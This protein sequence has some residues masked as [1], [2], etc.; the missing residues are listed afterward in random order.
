MTILNLGF[1][2]LIAGFFEYLNHQALIRMWNP[3]RVYGKEP[4]RM[5]ASIY[6]FD[7][8]IYSSRKAYTWWYNLAIW[9]TGKY[10]YFVSAGVTLFIIGLV[11]LNCW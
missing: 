9:G 10:M 8:M 4:S 1:L 6:K 11:C 7:Q 5:L 3:S 2:F